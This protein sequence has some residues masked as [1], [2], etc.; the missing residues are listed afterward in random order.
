MI[1]PSRP[2]AHDFA[3]T[4]ASASDARPIA[5]LS[6]DTIEIGLGWSWTPRRVSRAI[7]DP[8]VN[9]IVARD[10]ALLTGF[11]VMRYLDDEAHLLLLAVHARARR[12]GLGSALLRWLEHTARVAGIREIRL[13]SRYANRAARAFYAAH[14]YDTVGVRR[15]YYSG[16][17]DAACLGKR[18]RDS[19]TP[20]A[21]PDLS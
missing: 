3:I 5:E 2:A 17:E 4:L 21:L 11:A 12:A 14:G 20:P 1:R 18:L 16:V 7:A 19:D 9:V 6:R 15:G 8:A 10:G 13:E